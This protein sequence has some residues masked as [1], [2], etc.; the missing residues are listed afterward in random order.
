MVFVDLSRASDESNGEGANASWTASLPSVLSN[1][2]L[3]NIGEA[4]REVVEWS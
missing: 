3:D 4:D 1:L 2:S